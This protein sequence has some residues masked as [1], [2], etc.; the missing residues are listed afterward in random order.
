MCLG[1]GWTR[2]RIA[3]GEG[4][5]KIGGGDR[6]QSRGEHILVRLGLVATTTLSHWGAIGTCMMQLSKR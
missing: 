4:L 5:S 2:R 3:G 6:W 1:C